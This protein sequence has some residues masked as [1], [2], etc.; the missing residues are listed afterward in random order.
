[1]VIGDAVLMKLCFGSL[2]P[3][4]SQC[5]TAES[6]YTAGARHVLRLLI[7]AMDHGDLSLYHEHLQSNLKT[8]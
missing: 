6:T 1:M 5:P 4:S 7:L 2:L 3:P 8:G